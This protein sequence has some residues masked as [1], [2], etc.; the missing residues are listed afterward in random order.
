MPNPLRPQPYRIRWPLSPN[1][2]EGIDEM[3]QI[4]FKKA[5][6]LEDILNDPSG[7]G[8]G[9]LQTGTYTPVLTNTTNLAASTAFLT[10][11]YRVGS[12]V[13]VSGRVDVDPTAAGST[14]LGISLPIPSSFANN[15]ELGGTAFAPGIAGQGAA[16]LADAVNNRATMQWI[17]VDVTNQPMF[18]SFTYRVL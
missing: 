10:Q 3:L 4:L 2:V 16:L 8:I 13:T 14:V 9:A 6:Q 7:L 18:F 17:A 12:M 15:F 5:R 11:F 1:Q